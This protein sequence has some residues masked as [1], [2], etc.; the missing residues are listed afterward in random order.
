MTAGGWKPVPRANYM[1]LHAARLQATMPPSGWRAPR[2]PTFRRAP[3]TPTP[4]WDGTIP[5]AGS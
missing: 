1:Y 4:T 3:T 5:S 2:A